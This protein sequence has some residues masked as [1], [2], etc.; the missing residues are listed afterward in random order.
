MES[1]VEKLENELKWSIVVEM[2]SVSLCV[3]LLINNP[4]VSNRATTQG[5][6]GCWGLVLKAVLELLR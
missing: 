3:Q 6:G 4:V 1:K 2:E 5:V